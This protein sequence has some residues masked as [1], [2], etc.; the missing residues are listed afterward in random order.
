[1]GIFLIETKENWDR[2]EAA[3]QTW[4]CERDVGGDDDY[5]RGEDGVTPARR[6]FERM[7]EEIR[8]ALEPVRI[9][10]DTF[11]SQISRLCM[12]N[13]TDRALVLVRNTRDDYQLRTWVLVPLVLITW[14][15][16]LVWAIIKLGLP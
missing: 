4:R 14:P 7:Q 16:R 1:M 5:K 10:Q 6:Q 11:V 9:R 8:E 12:A 2:V 13:N 15:F 3:I